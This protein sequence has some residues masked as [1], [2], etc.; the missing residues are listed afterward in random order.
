MPHRDES[1]AL[2]LHGPDRLE[3]AVAGLSGADLDLTRAPGEWTIRQ[4][5]HHVA[6]GELQWAA[7]IKMAL[8]EPGRIYAHNLMDEDRWAE[9]LDYAGRPIDPSLALFR[10]L[11]AHVAQLV[12]RLP[13]SWER[14]VSF[15]EDAEWKPSV[16]ELIGI[17]SRHSLEHIEEILEDRRHHGL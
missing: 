3:S 5:V 9:A 8:A 7:P 1:S 2:Y 12:G 15:G 10:A 4:I 17:M 14:Y 6:D 11:R 16:A 13:D